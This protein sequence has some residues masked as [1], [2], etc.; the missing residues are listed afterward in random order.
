MPFIITSV[1]SY[2]YSLWK[3]EHSTINLSDETAHGDECHH[4]LSDRNQSFT[5][6]VRPLDFC[7]NIESFQNKYQLI[8]SALKSGIYYETNLEL[9]NS[10]WTF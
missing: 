3:T 9:C 8:Y 10:L 7:S 1:V 2:I 5:N 6:Y 4:I